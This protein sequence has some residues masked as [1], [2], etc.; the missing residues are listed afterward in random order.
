MKKLLA[1]LCVLATGLAAAQAETRAE[2]ERYIKAL[3]G[4]SCTA[5]QLPLKVYDHPTEDR[6]EVGHWPKGHGTIK[7]GQVDRRGQSWVYV[8]NDDSPQ[9]KGWTLLDDLNCI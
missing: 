5:A 2:K 7:R 3:A 9:Q 8:Q 4:T 1:C 6:Q